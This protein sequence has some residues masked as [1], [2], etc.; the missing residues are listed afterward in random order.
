M[1]VQDA[2]GA[3]DVHTHV[4]PENFPPYARR[5]AGVAWP[6]MVPAHSC[7]RHVMLSGEVYRTVSDRCWDVQAR[8]ADMVSQRVAKQVLSPMPELLS[9]WLDGVDGAALARYVN[10]VIATMVALE[11]TRFFGLGAVPL[12]DMDRALAE[13]DFVTRHL[14]L[15][16]VEV[17]TNVNGTAI[18]DPQFEPFFAAAESLGAA[19]FVH[20]LRP[21]GVERLIGPKTLEQIVAFPGESG[22]AAASLLT[23]GTLLRHPALRIALSHGGGSL[24]M[25]LPRLQHG[26]ETFEGIR[27]AMPLSPTDGAR[28]MYYDSLVYDQSTLEHLLH[29]FGSSQICVGSDFPF[30]ISETRPVACIEALPV[31]PNVQDLLLHRNAERWLDSLTR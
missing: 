9:Y 13:L 6:S 5:A 19:V 11:P 18:G 25:L 3:I 10:E 28:R 21:S 17:G 29:R 14:K 1:T 23:G 15:S 2:C 7:H 4:V 30:R 8:L 20:P 24:A 31:T 16:G 27:E 12:Q 22:L 26:W